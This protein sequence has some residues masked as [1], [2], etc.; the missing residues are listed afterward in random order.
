MSDWSIK[1]NARRQKQR[2]SDFFN[3]NDVDNSDKT[4][5]SRPPIMTEA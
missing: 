3:I 1:G 4:M 2:L 5:T